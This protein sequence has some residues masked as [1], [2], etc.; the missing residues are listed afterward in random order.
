M[1][2]Q[3]EEDT[4]RRYKVTD[5]TRPLATPAGIRYPEYDQTEIVNVGSSPLD[6]FTEFLNEH[7]EDILDWEIVNS[8]SSRLTVLYLIEVD[9]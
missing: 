4:G 1:F 7:G 5:M 2:V 3:A 9:E 6:Q 8:S